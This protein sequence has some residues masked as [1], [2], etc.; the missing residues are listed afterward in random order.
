MES[1]PFKQPSKM[2]HGILPASC[3]SFTCPR[4]TEGSWDMLIN[5]TQYLVVSY[6]SVKLEGEKN[7]A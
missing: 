3:Y 4:E 1:S 5:Y 7:R 2:A 6:P